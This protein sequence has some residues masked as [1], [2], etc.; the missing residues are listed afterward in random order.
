[1]TH[2][3]VAFQLS[4]I[5]LGLPW[6]DMVP[7]YSLATIDQLKPHLSRAWLVPYITTTS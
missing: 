3:A 5:G 6:V 2:G 1:M 7:R 4:V